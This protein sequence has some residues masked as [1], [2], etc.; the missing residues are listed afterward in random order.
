MCRALCSWHIVMI[1]TM[2]GAGA[3]DLVG[4]LLPWVNGPIQ[5]RILL[6]QVPVG[7]C[8]NS[9]MWIRKHYGTTN[10]LNPDLMRKIKLFLSCWSDTCP[11]CSEANT[12]GHPKE[13]YSNCFKRYF[14]RGHWGGKNLWKPPG[15]LPTDLY[16]FSSLLNLSVASRAVSTVYG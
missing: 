3:W 10:A 2:I 6:L 16:C 1:L 8:W 4:G 5:Q 7:P 11:S 13:L 9:L 15:T 12:A 14:S